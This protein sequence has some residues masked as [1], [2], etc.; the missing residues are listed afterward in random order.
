MTFTPDAQ[1]YADTLQEAGFTVYA[2]P[3]NE[4]NR[5]RPVSWFHYSR[6]VDGETLYGTYH[7]GSETFGVSD[8]AM[9]IP[10]TRLNGS[11]AHIAAS[12]VP[13]ESVEYAM[14][15]TRRS[16]WCPWNYPVTAENVS[17]ANA[18]RPMPKNAAKGATLLNAKPWGIGTT[19]QPLP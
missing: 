2:N 11:S 8:H 16:N 15:I 17:R 18:M 5:R 12:G 7:D 9:P 1:T 6:E 19:Y 13:I 3:D 14:L 10:P 4:T